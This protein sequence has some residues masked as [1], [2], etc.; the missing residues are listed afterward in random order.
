MKPEIPMRGLA[1]ALAAVLFGSQAYA[2]SGAAIYQRT[3]RKYPYA[4]PFVF[5]FATPS[6]AWFLPEAEWNRLTPKD[7]AKV[8]EYM[9]VLVAR[10]R[11]NPDPY[12]NMP[13]SAPLYETAI[14]KVRAFSDDQ[15]EIGVGQPAGSGNGRTLTMDTQVV[16]GASASDDCAGES[17]AAV[18]AKAR[19]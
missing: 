9:P 4:K 14:A 6:L 13:S 18:L 17:A 3:L 12:L 19:Q 15:W 10:A 5:G 11:A 16:C 2:Q 1:L 8:V 7:R